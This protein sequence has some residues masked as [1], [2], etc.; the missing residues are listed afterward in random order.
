MINFHIKQNFKELSWHEVSPGERFLTV[1][2]FSFFM[3]DVC[4]LMAWVFF[5]KMLAISLKPALIIFVAVLFGQI[6]LV[7]I[8]SFYFHRWFKGLLKIDAELDKIL[9]GEKLSQVSQVLGFYPGRLYK[10]IRMLS[11]RQVVQLEQL[12]IIRTK[13]VDNLADIRK[14]LFS[15]DQCAVLENDSVENASRYIEQVRQSVEK[16]SSEIQ[17]MMIS[18]GNTVYSVQVM[19]RSIAEVNLNA[20]NMGDFIEDTSQVIEELATFILEIIK[21]VENAHLLSKKSHESASMGGKAVQDVINAITQI[22]VNMDGFSKTMKT[23]GKQSQEIGKITATIDDIAEQTNLLALNAAI[24]AS[25][26]GEQGKGFGIV[27][28]EIKKLAGKTSHATK[29]ITRMIKSIQD[30]VKLVIQ[31][32]EK[33]NEQVR[34][35]VIVSDKA[36]DALGGIVQISQ[37]VTHFLDEIHSSVAE[38]NKASQKIMESVIT[39][40]KLTQQVTCST[41]DQNENSRLITDVV[42]DMQKVTKGVVEMLNSQI[43]GI[44]KVNKS[45][46]EVMRATGLLMSTM[47]TM[48]YLSK[49][50][51]KVFV[52]IDDIMELK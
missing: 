7:G 15:L 31:N 52:E 50:F 28:N 11:G 40:K 17:T 43:N 45:M 8:L 9:K 2:F 49:N 36:G 12:Q 20:Q 13:L 6:V 25:R 10:K 5:G 35:G 1:I 33:G 32:V 4:Y 26:A 34:Q 30:D 27:A 46:N 38:Q 3:V 47:N 44:E 21:N 19:E 14:H 42:L 48:E 18:V 29:E 23:L 24:E 16:I 22:S 37:E 41:R 39:M 51:K